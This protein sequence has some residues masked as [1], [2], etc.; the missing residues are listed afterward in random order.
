VAVG[1][2]LPLLA[3]CSSLGG[4]TSNGDTSFVAGDGSTV[5]LAAA[6]RTAPVEFSG[7][8]LGG[9][10]FE[11]AKYRGQVVVLNVWASWC[12]PC[13]AEAPALARPAKELS[14]K[15]VQFVGVNI[16]DSDAAAA[17]FVQRFA[18]PYPSVVDPDSTRLL[19]FRSTLPAVSVP[20]TLVI[21]QQGRV[22]GRAL[23]EVDGSLLKGL[24]EPLLREAATS[25]SA[26]A[27]SPS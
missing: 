23:S 4:L 15:G 17:A 1:A 9:G 3:G 19:A 14:A 25:G 13:R 11:L 5:L 21:D 18:L 2:A 20:T 26:P 7:P 12:A 8:T 24:V 10:S 16:R 22:A 6:D 27:A